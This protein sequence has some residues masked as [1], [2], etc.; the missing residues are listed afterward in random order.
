L[1]HTFA[2]TVDTERRLVYS[3]T[4]FP[5]NVYDAGKELLQCDGIELTPNAQVT[6]NV[7]ITK[8]GELPTWAFLTLLT[9]LITRF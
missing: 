9:S 5:A 7:V 6:G 4:I 2:L 1:A 3:L 8:I